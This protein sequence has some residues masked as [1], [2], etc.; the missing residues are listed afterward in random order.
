MTINDK[1]RLSQN[2]AVIAG[3]FCVAVALLLL[4][5]FALLKKNDPLKVKHYRRWWNG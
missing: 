5:N 4:L 1:I 3:I 2:T